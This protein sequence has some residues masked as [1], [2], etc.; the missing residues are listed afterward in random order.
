MSFVEE[1]NKKMYLIDTKVSPNCSKKNNI[2]K[3]SGC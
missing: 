3:D 1:G 2:G